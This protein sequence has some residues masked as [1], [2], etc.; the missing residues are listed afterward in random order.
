HVRARQTVIASG[1]IER[2]LVFGNNDR[3]GVMLAAAVST[4]INRYAVAPGRRAV[5]FANNDG[6]YRTALDLQRA[7]V[8]VAA[9]LDART[10]PDSAWREAASAAG[11]EVRCGHV[12]TDVRGG[13]RV[14]AV[15]TAAVADNGR[16]FAGEGKTIK[17]DLVAM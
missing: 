4:Y 6:G 3:P 10:N 14:Q 12:A 17:C 2:P 11:L 7:G 8:K 1:A 15:C 5:V 16:R 13:K 9:V